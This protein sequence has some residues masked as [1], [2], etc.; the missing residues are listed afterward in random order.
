MS[1][2]NTG[3]RTRIRSFI[4]SRFPLYR[5]GNLGDEDSLLDQG[6]IDSLGILDVVQFLEKDFGVHVEDEEL[7][8]A[9]FESVAALVSFV[10]GK[11]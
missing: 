9:N 8:P 6:V 3:P 7:N 5:D 2:T 10:E 1:E 4:E 11:K